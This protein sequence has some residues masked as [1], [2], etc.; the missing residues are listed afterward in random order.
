M[1]KLIT[2]I[3]ASALAATSVSAANFEGKVSYKISSGRDKAQEMT[4]SI[5][6]KKMRMEIP[7]QKEMGPMIMDM[8]KKEMMMTMPSD[9]MYMT[10]AIPDAATDA[11][12]KA[13]DEVTL[14]KTSE[15]E[16]ILGYTATKYI[17]TDS[18]GVVSDL[19]LA[20]GLGTF[21]PMSNQN[22]MGRSRANASQ[23]GWERALAGK[24][25][26][27]L[28]VVSKDKSGKESFRMEVTKIEKKSLP[29]SD[30]EAPAGYQKFD[31]GGMMKGLIPGFGR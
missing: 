26:F 8:E 7:N 22:P 1:K 31:M 9:H 27:P 2:L 20:E 10:M 13:R 11:A 6:G 12:A 14:E 4:Y 15:T 18:K 19:W 24:E 28:R 3:C 16:K 5:K 23:K 30:F 29:D 25:M 21:M 17:S